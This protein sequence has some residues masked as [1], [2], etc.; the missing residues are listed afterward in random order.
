M[1][2]ILLKWFMAFNT[3]LIRAS[4]GRIGSEMA[5]QTILILHTTGRNSGQ[6]REVPISYFRDGENFFVIGSNWGRKKHADW[7]FNLK[8][9]PRASVELAGKKIP[10]LARDAEGDEYAR[11]WQAAI[12]RRPAY[13]DYLKTAGRHIP[14]VVLQPVR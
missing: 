12:K 10:V 8:R 4:G 13:Q 1:K 11:M 3:F 2:N 7:Y 5:G 6:P 9:E 14:I